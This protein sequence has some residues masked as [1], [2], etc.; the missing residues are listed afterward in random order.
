MCFSRKQTHLLNIATPFRTQQAAKC[1]ITDTWRLHEHEISPPR[2]EMAGLMLSR[3]AL[4]MSVAVFAHRR[5]IRHQPEVA[6]QLKA[7]LVL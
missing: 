5:P 4:D 3:V 6:M 1:S 7:T 2:D